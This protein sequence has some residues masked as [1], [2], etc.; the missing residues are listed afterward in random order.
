[1]IGLL[2]RGDQTA[3]HLH[4][5]NECCPIQ[6]ITDAM[7]ADVML[8]TVSNHNQRQGE[9]AVNELLL[10]LKQGMGS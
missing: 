10:E 9:G 8:D 6:L 4:R 3:G 7:L 2:L 5:T 1:M